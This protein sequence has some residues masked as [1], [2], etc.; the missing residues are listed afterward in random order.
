[1]DPC[2]GIRLFGGLEATPSV[3]IDIFHADVT[4]ILRDEFWQFDRVDGAT[5]GRLSLLYRSAG[6]QWRDA[7]GF[8]VS[9]VAGVHNVAVVQRGQPVLNQWKFTKDAFNFNV[10]TP[11]DLEAFPASTDGWLMSGILSSFSPFTVGFSGITVLG[12]LPVKLLS[13]EGA[14]QGADARLQW[15]IDSDK[16]LQQFELQYSTDGSSFRSIASLAPAGRQYQYLHRGLAAGKH[17]YRLLVKEKTG[18]Q[19]Y[20]KTVLLQRSASATYVVGLQQNPVGS[21]LAL[22]LWSASAQAAEYSLTD[23]GGRQLLRQRS[24]LLPGAN[25][26]RMPVA[27]LPA[28]V[29]HLTVLTAD[30][31]Q[32][33]L[34]VLKQ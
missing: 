31:V 22:N 1:M 33:T 34:R 25:Q 14:W 18:Q 21:S 30:G 32:E 5:A 9:P 13:F 28:G 3:G 19:Y 2:L 8:A 16:D 12:T 10:A 17:Y 7:A 11:P 27:K 26:L 20:S 6:A 29:Y 4:G 15:R 24:Q 23:M